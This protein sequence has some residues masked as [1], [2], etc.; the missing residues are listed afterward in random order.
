[1]V[2]SLDNNMAWDLSD[3]AMEYYKVLILLQYCNI[4]SHFA[5]KGLV[6]V[7][8]L[9]EKQISLDLPRFLFKLSWN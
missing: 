2:Q 5:S 6:M 1:M 9:Q 3:I 4:A 8:L 7:I